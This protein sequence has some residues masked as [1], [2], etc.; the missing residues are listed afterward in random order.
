MGSLMVAMLVAVVIGMI[1]I[2]MT[3]KWPA[4]EPEP[5]A[6]WECD[7][8]GTDNPSQVLQCRQCGMDAMA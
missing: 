3:L 1:C 6:S 2:G 4:D 7:T 8:C 5:A